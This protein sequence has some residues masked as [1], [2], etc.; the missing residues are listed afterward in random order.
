MSSARK[1]LF[2]RLSYLLSAVEAYY[3]RLAGFFVWYFMIKPVLILEISVLISKYE[4]G[5]PWEP[6]G[7][8][9]WPAELAAW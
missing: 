7:G 5:Y 6:T 9:L 2:S 1:P 4:K 3:I 8:L